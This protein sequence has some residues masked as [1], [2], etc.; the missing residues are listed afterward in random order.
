LLGRLI[1]KLSGKPY[2]QFITENIISKLELQQC[3]LAFTITNF[4]NYVTGYQKNLTFMN[5]LLGFFLDK[6]KFMG[7]AEGKWKPFKAFYINGPSYGGLIGTAN[8]FRKYIQQLLKPTNSLLD[9]ASRKLL[10]EENHTNNDTATG[11]CLSWFCA[12][13]NGRKYFAHPGGGGGYYC[14]LRLYPEINRGSVVMFNRTG[15]S[16][17]KFLDKVDKIFL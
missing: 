8:S 1:E 11:M 10:F 7:Q 15:I 6:S 4:E 2:E 16:N 12:D 3:E 14:E 9:E 17:E 5:L 13:L